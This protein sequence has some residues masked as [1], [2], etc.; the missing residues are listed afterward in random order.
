MAIS[1][2]LFFCSFCAALSHSSRLH[3]RPPGA[4]SGSAGQV[5]A[6]RR[7]QKR[8]GVLQDGGRPASAAQ[9]Q[10]ALCRV[11]GDG[12]ADHRPGHHGWRISTAQ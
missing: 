2:L 8:A 10:Q 5:E 11:Q 12:H 1:R 3:A 7:D 9:I 4:G 6:A